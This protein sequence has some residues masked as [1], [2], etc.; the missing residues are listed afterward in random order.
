MILSCTATM[1]S[2]YYRGDLH[3]PKDDRHATY[4]YNGGGKV[5]GEDIHME[6]SSFGWKVQCCNRQQR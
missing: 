6:L 4:R 5:E 2:I 1:V 3:A